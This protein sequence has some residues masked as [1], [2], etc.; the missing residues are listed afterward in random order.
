MNKAQ[1]LLKE[2]DGYLSPEDVAAFPGG[3]KANPMDAS[4][5]DSDLRKLYQEYL[6]HRTRP[7]VKSNF[8]PLTF[9]Q[10]KKMH[11]ARSGK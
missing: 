9:E 3:G 11:L 5:S 2:V 4:T 10:W 1:R 8:K 7:N 6:T